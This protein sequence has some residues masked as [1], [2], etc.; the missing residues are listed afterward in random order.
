MINAR[1]KIFFKSLGESIAA[2]LV[3]I[4]VI[5]CV[6][7]GVWILFNAPAG[8]SIAIIVLGVIGG[9]TYYQYK[10]K[11]NELKY[12]EER[13]KETQEE[14]THL[15]E[16]IASIT[17]DLGYPREVEINYWNNL[18]KDAQEVYDRLIKKRNSL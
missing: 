18:L 16:K 11:L 5:A 7:G 4:A 13:L 15:E 6:M 12:I 10:E 8:I 3:A 14:I 1:V 2:L 9:L 17:D